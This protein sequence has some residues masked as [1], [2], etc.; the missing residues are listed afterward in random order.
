VNNDE[1]GSSRT[2][3]TFQGMAMV[4]DPSYFFL[5]LFLVML[6]NLLDPVEIGIAV[7]PIYFSLNVNRGS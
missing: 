7:L 3:A 4:E 6:E 5:P 2:E 1:K